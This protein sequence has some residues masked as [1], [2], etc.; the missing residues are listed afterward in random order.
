MYRTLTNVVRDMYEN[1]HYSNPHTPI[2]DTETKVVDEPEDK[3]VETEM[4]SNK[5]GCAETKKKLYAKIQNL[6]AQRQL[7]IVDNA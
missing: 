6:K 1:K 4:P 7:K 3:P 5:D 2:I